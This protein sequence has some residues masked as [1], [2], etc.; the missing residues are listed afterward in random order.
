MVEGSLV[1]VEAL[2]EEFDAR[3]RAVY[4]QPNDG[5]VHAFIP[6]SANPN[7]GA[8]SPA[9]VP[10]R[11]LIEAGG[12]RGVTIFPPGSEAVR[13]SQ[14]PEGAEP[15]AALNHVLMDFL[16]VVES[17]RYVSSGARAVVE[18][19]GPRVA[20]GYPRVNE[21]LGS[22]TVSIA[23]CVLAHVLR[24]P[25]EYGGEEESGGDVLGYF[26]VAPHG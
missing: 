25:V 4:H 9:V 22:Y 14:L 16:E 13:L 6:I 8:F 20:S 15:E 21:C 5:R 26:K 19:A 12:V 11:V 10:N 2:L 1:N 17:V 23:G 3:G 18:L 24:R 7:L